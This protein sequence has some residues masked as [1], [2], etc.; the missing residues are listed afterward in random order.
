MDNPQP[1]VHLNKGRAFSYWTSEIPHLQN[2]L[3]SIQSISQ[4]S[5]SNRCSNDTLDCHSIDSSIETRF[6]FE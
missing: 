3:V 5:P 1:A 6:S 4:R 2:M